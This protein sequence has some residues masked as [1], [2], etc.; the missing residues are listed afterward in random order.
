MDKFIGD[1][2]KVFPPLLLWSL[3]IALTLF[4]APPLIPDHITG[5]K[6][7]VSCFFTSL[8]LAKITQAA[9]VFYR[10]GRG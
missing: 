5:W 10:R 9:W 8:S 1:T 3:C 4:V 6:L 2:E 7:A